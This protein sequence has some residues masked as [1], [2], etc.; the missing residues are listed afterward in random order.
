MS[1][2]LK[3]GVSMTARQEAHGLIDRMPEESVQALIPVMAKLIPFRKK[4]ADT[5][6]SG[7]SPK[8]Q[9]FLDMEEMRKESVKYNISVS[10]REAAMA[11]K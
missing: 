1:D 6:T 4:Q 5:N 2:G 11:E 3:G 8:M 9:A 7:I 10:Q